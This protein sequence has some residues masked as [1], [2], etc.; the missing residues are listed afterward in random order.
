MKKV[1]L[2]ALFATVIFSHS[3]SDAQTLPAKSNINAPSS[4]GVS[5]TTNPPVA[6]APANSPQAATASSPTVTSSLTIAP[7]ADI[8]SLTA[9]E[10]LSANNQVVSHIAS[11]YQ[12]LGL[13]I[14]I[15]V[16]LV[17]GVATWMSF[18]ARRSVHEFIQ[19]WS[20]KLESVENEMKESLK[21]LREAV[22]EAET[23]ANK[24][25]KHARSIEDSE[26]VLN[27]TLI[28]VDRLRAKLSGE[29]S[30]VEPPEPIAEAASRPPSPEPQTA[31]EDAEV[32]AR[33]QGKIDSPEGEGHKP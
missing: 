8:A 12:N 1:T 31:E 24:A 15:I 10:I 29:Q 3:A 9:K 19:E 18:V 2:I 32:A 26:K 14:T 20:K 7:P 33:L 13:F 17:G 5:V 16:T 4:P 11:M 23:S 27:K 25:A 30:A 6:A 21:R 28:E 22:G